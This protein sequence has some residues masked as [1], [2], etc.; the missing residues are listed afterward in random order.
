MRQIRTDLAME[1]AG[2]AGKSDL[3]GVNISAW[4]AGEVQITEV[5]VEAGEGAKLLGKA[6]GVYITLQC[7]AA[8]RREADARAAVASLLGEELLRLLPADDGRPVLVI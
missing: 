1:S 4:E 2:A 3:P 6:P 8:R 5:R 7:E